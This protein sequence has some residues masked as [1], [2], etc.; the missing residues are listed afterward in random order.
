MKRIA[1][2]LTLLLAVVMVACAGGK[3][4]AFRLLNADPKDVVDYTVTSVTKNPNKETGW[5]LM[6]RLLVKDR[7]DLDEKTARA[8]A[9][10]FIEKNKAQHNGMKFTVIGLKPED[11][12]LPGVEQIDTV[13]HVAWAASSAGA[14]AAGLSWNGKTVVSFQVGP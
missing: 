11:P 1:I 2:W 13:Y 4:E 6:A 8:V 7:P 14:K 10:D 5:L 3:P 9:A 12:K